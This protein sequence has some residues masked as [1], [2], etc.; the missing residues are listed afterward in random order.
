[1]KSDFLLIREMKQGNRQAFD[2]FVRKYYREI[3]KYCLYHCYD[4]RYAEDLAQETFVRFFSKL[5]SYQHTGKTKNYLYKIAGNLCKDFYKK[6][7]ETPVEDE[8]LYQKVEAGENLIDGFIEKHIIEQ[9]L[10]QLQPELYEVI[11]LYY[12]QE[13][14]QKEISD[15]LQIG[16]PLVKYRLGK[17]K[18]QLEKIIK[19]ED[20]R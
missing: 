16:L 12:F 11:V 6:M 18:E 10:H 8:V 19:K 14:K 5:S 3:L 2:L 7:K 1:M 15:I 9:S 20:T 4:Q 17:A 13:L